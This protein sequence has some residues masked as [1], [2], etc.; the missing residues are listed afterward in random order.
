MW[1]KLSKKRLFFVFNLQGILLGAGE[2]A[3]NEH[4][5]LEH[6][7]NRGSIVEVQVSQ[8]ITITVQH[9]GPE[10]STNVGA[11]FFT[12]SRAQG[13]SG[14]RQVC[15]YLTPAEGMR[16]VNAMDGRFN[17]DTTFMMFVSFTGYTE[18]KQ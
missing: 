6:K 2:A 9:A 18:G 11:A 7:V 17:A 15:R 3:H 16:T 14:Q 1:Q 8:D 13:P 5:L 10:R 12:L 4:T